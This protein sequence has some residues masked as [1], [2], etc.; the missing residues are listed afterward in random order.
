M[1]VSSL[2]FTLRG[3]PTRARRKRWGEITPAQHFIIL[4]R[5]STLAALAV[6]SRAEGGVRLPQELPVKAVR[7]LSRGHTAPMSFGG[8]RSKIT[9]HSHPE[10]KRTPSLWHH[11]INSIE[12]RL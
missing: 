6:L 4:E 7:A 1:L 12:G 2:C 10:S 8:S 5:C 9:A 3:K 11:V